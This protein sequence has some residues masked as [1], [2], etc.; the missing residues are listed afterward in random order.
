MRITKLLYISFLLLICSTGTHGQESLTDYLKMAAQNN[1]EVKAAYHRYQAAL[2]KVPQAGSLPDPEASFGF[3]PEPMELMGGDQLGNVQL[4]QM[5]PWFGTL[6]AAKDEASKMALAQ[7]EAY[8]A[9]KA[10]LSYQVRQSW[11]QLM[12]YDREID[13]VRENLDLL[14]SLEKLVLVKLQSPATGASGQTMQRPASETSSGGMPSTMRSQQTGLQDVLQVKMDILDQKNRQDLLNDQRQTEQARFNALMNRD[15]NIQVSISDSLIK[16]TLPAGKLAL[17]DSILANNPML[18]MLEKE[19]DSYVSM[20]KKAKK[21]GMPMLGLGLS[22]MLIQKRAGNNSMM[23][24][25]DMFMPMA[26][27]SIPVFRKKYRAMQNE[28]RLMQEATRQQMTSTKNDLLVQYRRLIQEL[29]DAD[30]RISLYEEQEELA[31]KAK[32][33]L[34]SGFTTTGTDYE[35]VLR[36]Q[37]K[38]LDYGFKHI[39]AI[40]SYNTSAAMAE[41]LMNQQ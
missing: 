33:L 5:F 23:N 13:L 14:G 21:M 37:M 17:A 15:T 31:R 20:E 3:Y 34:L 9:A 22:Y 7:Y 12:K 24:G 16:E 29:D 32:E 30:R 8:H 6:K 38:V 25:N 11:Y 35:E 2:E 36:M 26:S 41:K 28:A 1:P 18:S 39:E 10:G 4:M 40:V 19:A 27:V